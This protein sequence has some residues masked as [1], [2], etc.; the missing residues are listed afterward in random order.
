MILETPERMMYGPYTMADI[1]S[2]ATLG[3]VPLGSTLHTMNGRALTLAEV[4]L[5]TIVGEQA[6]AGPV[7]PGGLTK[8]TKW[9]IAA[10]VLAVALPVVGL[11][12][13]MAGG[14][15]ATA[16]T[17]HGQAQ[18]SLCRQHLT[19][20]TLSVRFYV[21]DHDGV[22]PNATNWRQEIAPYLL[23]DSSTFVCA[24]SGRKQDSYEFNS[25]LSGRAV[26]TISQRDKTPMIYEAGLRQGQGPHRDGGYIA[27]V[28]G[29][30]E[31]V[32]ADSF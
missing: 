15:A 22:L 5:A 12:V 14:P 32:A 27:Y 4:G 26:D 28:N 20:L 17:T 7:R 8:G 3:R 25:A 1:R 10:L 29:D 2:F 31:W 24:A 21:E 6:F 18:E 23:G 13:L 9:G 30:V 19:Q 11:G 16:R